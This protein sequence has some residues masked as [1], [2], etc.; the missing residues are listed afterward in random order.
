[1]PILVLCGS[2]LGTEQLTSSFA[3]LIDLY[4]VLEVPPASIDN[5][6]PR[7]HDELF[8]GPRDSVL[9]KGYVLGLDP[10]ILSVS[11]HTLLA[12]DDPVMDDAWHDELVRLREVCVQHYLSVSQEFLPDVLPFSTTSCSW[13]GSP[14]HDE[15]RLQSAKHQR[16]R[17]T[18]LDDSGPLFPHGCVTWILDE[19][20]ELERLRDV[21]FVEGRFVLECVSGKKNSELNGFLK[22]RNYNH[23]SGLHGYENF[24]LIKSDLILKS[25]KFKACQWDYMVN[26]KSQMKGDQERHIVA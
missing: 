3:V 8:A 10:Y 4:T 2:E 12:M 25:Q 17:I 11:L 5:L 6:R 20:L 22:N 13:T 14:F 26:S 23:V 1:M 9:H 19:M 16:L 18:S 21:L 24:I 7:L 15:F